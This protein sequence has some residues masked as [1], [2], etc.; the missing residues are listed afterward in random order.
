MPSFFE[1]LKRLAQGKPGFE[2]GD[3]QQDG[4]QPK[5]VAD[6]PAIIVQQPKQL[7]DHLGTPID[8][9]GN[10][11]IPVVVVNEIK[12]HEAGAAMECWGVL[13]N[14]SDQ[15]VE[16]D[17][18]ALLGAT[19]EID[20]PLRAREEREFLLYKG[21]RPRNTSQTRAM[22]QYKNEAGDYFVAEH[23]IEYDGLPDGTWIVNELRFLP[24]VRDI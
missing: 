16:V 15:T 6:E 9:H 24:P 22:V 19:H 4:K 20:H 10:K 8:A 12:C 7:T 14:T 3:V 18:V 13:E 21:P 17:K 5:P 2:V 23:Y 11:I 1:V